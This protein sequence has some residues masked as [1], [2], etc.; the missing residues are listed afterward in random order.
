[1]KD[2]KGKG[3]C[4]AMK[5]RSPHHCAHIHHRF[6]PHLSHDAPFHRFPNH[7][8]TSANNMALA[9]GAY[10]VPQ[11]A[12]ARDRTKL[13][14]SKHTCGDLALAQI[15]LKKK[16]H[17]QPTRLRL[18]VSRDHFSERR[19]ER[20]APCPRGRAWPRGA[21]PGSLRGVLVVYYS[22]PSGDDGRRVR[23]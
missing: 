6:P 4:W 20:S 1:L 15:N 23:S 18:A 17:S 2:C 14:I 13:A 12:N 5:R 16:S 3:L 10:V 9:V 7:T 22:W 11:T 19:P 8:C 21:R